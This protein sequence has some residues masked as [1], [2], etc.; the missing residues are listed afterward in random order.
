M[1]NP[2]SL[3]ILTPERVFYDGTADV[4]TITAPDGKYSI[5][6]GHQPLITSLEIGTMT[7]RTDDEWRTVFN[8]EGFVEV[9]DDGVIIY[10]QTCEYPEEI[11]ASRAESARLRAEELLRQQRSMSEYKQTKIAL[12]RAMARLQV[13]QS[14][15]K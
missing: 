4:V 6:A 1:Y 13:T 14:R 5:L 11:D 2:F 15:R 10:S 7:F 12:A 8:S 3:K 9:S